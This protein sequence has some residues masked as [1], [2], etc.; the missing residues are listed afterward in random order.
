MGIRH[1]SSRNE[2]RCLIV[3]V[4][5]GI[6]TVQNAGFQ[7]PP[8]MNMTLNP[9]LPYTPCVRDGQRVLHGDRIRAPFKGPSSVLGLSRLRARR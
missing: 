4:S 1:G 6:F 7:E 8:D 9:T 2:T 5:T 3:P